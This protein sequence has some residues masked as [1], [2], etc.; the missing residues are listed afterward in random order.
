MVKSRLTSALEEHAAVIDAQSLTI[1]DC[2]RLTGCKK[3]ETWAKE[4][5][6]F[7]LWLLDKEYTQHKLQAAAE[8]AINR[9]IEIMNSDM[10]EKMLTA[11]DK[12]K[13]AETI[14]TLA[15]RFPSKHKVIEWKDKDVGKMEDSDVKR[16]LE[17]M[18][19]RLEKAPST[20]DVILEAEDVHIEDAS[21]A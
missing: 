11:K 16:Q 18:K 21:K 13:A 7:I 9:L 5:P 8:V 19:K 14:L 4:S 6:N 17:A 3:I 10:V 20:E 15:D 1:E 12:L 2:I